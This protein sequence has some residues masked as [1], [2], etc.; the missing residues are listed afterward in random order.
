[1]LISG[2]CLR[3]PECTHRIAGPNKGS[4]ILFQGVRFLFIR[5]KAV[6]VLVRLV[7]FQKNE[8]CAFLAV[9][10]H[11]VDSTVV[12]LLREYWP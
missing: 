12:D 8:V 7:K 3:T 11:Q 4:V 6:P 1:M 5:P 9:A 10:S 2:G